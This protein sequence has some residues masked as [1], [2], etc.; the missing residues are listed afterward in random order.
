MVKEIVF[1]D[2]KPYIATYHPLSEHALKNI[3]SRERNWSDGC[4]ARKFA[5]ERDNATRVM[6]MHHAFLGELEKEEVKT[7]LAKCVEE[8]RQTEE[9]ALDFARQVVG[10][11]AVNILLKKGVLEFDVG[12]ER[13]RIYK[14]GTVERY[15]AAQS[16]WRRLCVIKPNLP[17]L[18][19]FAALVVNVKEK[20]K[21]YPYV[22]R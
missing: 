8:R 5:A 16:L 7:W 2:G 14:S 15:D 11:Q 13:Y 22:G 19:V 1:R 3:L 21:P 17:Y 18:D 9:A 20:G 10:D 4:Q 6:A 12:K